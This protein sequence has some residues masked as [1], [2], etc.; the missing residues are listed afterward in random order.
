MVF[1][2]FFPQIRFVQKDIFQTIFIR[3]KHINQTKKSLRFRLIFSSYGCSSSA[4]GIG[5]A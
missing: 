5:P 1:K 4:E 3:Y 2:Y